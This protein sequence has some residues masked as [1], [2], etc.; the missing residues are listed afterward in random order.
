MRWDDIL[1]VLI[2]LERKNSGVKGA[3][4]VSAEGLP[5]ASAFF[6]SADE[7]KIAAMTTALLSLAEM[8]VIEM[9]K[10]EFDQIYIKGSDGYL[11]VMRAGPD[12]VLTISTTKDIRLGLIFLD[13]KR[14]CEKIQKLI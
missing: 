13:C 2:E 12:A 11:L 8:S 6:Q 14:T 3:I 9:G 5:I 1:N 7:T 4:L 10:G